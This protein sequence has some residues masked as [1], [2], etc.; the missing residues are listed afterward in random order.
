VAPEE[1]LCARGYRLGLATR[2]ATVDGREVPLSKTEFD[3]LAVL[4]GS[5]SRVFER[6][7]LLQRVWGD[8][9]VVSDRTVDVHVKSMRRKVQEAGGDPS[10]VETVRGVGY[11]FRIR[12]EG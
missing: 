1:T 3:I 2:L 10:A 8:D 4:L 9:C 12:D 5:P 7:H 6:D 11:R